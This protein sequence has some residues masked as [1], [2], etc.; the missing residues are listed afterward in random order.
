LALGVDGTPECGI[1]VRE[2]RFFERKTGQA[3]V[4]MGFNF[5]RLFNEVRTVDHDN[6]SR[7]GYDPDE[8]QQMLDRLA[9]HGFNTV[10]VFV[11]CQPGEVID[12]RD[13]T[14]LSAV[15]MDHVTDFLL[16]AGRSGIY[17]MLS[18]RRFPAMAR[19][20]QRCRPADPLVTGAN[21]DYLVPGW[22]QAKALYMQDFLR[23]ILQRNPTALTA[24]F[25]IDIQNE[26]CFCPG[27][28][29]FSL[30]EGSITAH[31]GSRYDLA[32]QKQD[33]ADDSA[34]HY[35]NTCAAAIHEVFPSVLINVNVFTYAAVGRRG[36]GDFHKDKAGWRN[37]VPFRPL[38]IARSRADMIDVH[39]YCSTLSR[40][41]ED[42]KSIEFARLRQV[43]QD[44]GKPLIVGEFGLFKEQFA[45]D[46]D[47]GRRFLRDDWLPALNRDWQ[48]WLYWT[49]DTHEQ[50]RLWNAADHSSAIF[51]ILAASAKARQASGE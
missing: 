5:V 30:A 17:V 23:E 44:A 6:F 7:S 26:V 14:G 34:I 27:E 45:G 8:Q 28:K 22:T 46:F 3:F 37:R 42:L 36:P 19:Y 18:M 41:Q 39:F 31:Y 51:K 16:R 33:L 15:Y 12:A 20:Q 29:P 2:G 13:A 49:Y 25:A 1:L 40:Y 38:A 35:I 48:G 9:E 24:L 21:R 11:N 50:P 32:T 47:A 4:P 43:A 10:R